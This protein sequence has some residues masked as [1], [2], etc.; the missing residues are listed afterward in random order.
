MNYLQIILLI[1]LLGYGYSQ[2]L[3]SVSDCVWQGSGVTL[4]LKLTADYFEYYDQDTYASYRYYPCTAEDWGLY[5]CLARD[6]PALCQQNSDSSLYVVGT[7]ASV[8]VAALT[9]DTFKMSYSGGYLG[10]EGKVTITC[11]QE[12]DSFKF[13]S[14]DYPTYLFSLSLRDACTKT[15][16]AAGVDGGGFALFIILILAC[17]FG[18][19][20]YITGGV[21]FMYF[22]KKE[23]GIGLIPNLAFWKAFPFLFRDGFLFTFSCIPKVRE[24]F[25]NKV[26]TDYEKIPS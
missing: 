1:S 9:E 24:Y 8:S 13:D 12:S 17:I 25:V 15:G 5:D 7:L 20:A 22:H 16:A 18:V 14:E 23:R 6:G 10:R 2:N 19:T 11:F 4:N 21:A 3:T 26:N